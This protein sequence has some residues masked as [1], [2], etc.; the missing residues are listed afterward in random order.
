MG[1]GSASRQNKN[2][3]S[4]GR[5]SCCVD[6]YRRFGFS[7]GQ[8]CYGFPVRVLAVVYERV[9]NMLEVQ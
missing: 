3:Y 4:C 5:V 1:E 9:V 2:P 8:H 7:S 6:K